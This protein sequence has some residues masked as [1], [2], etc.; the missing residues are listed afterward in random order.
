MSRNYI[1]PRA[2]DAG[3]HPEANEAIFDAAKRGWVKNI[4]FMAPG[5]TFDRA[6]AMSREIHGCDFG[7]HVSL[8]SEWLHQRFGPLRAREGAHVGADGHCVRT[9][10]IIFERGVVLDVLIDE[11]RAQHE[12]AV[13][14]G[15]R[16]SYLDEH[17][18]CS[19]LHEPGRPE[20]RLRDF[21]M[22]FCAEKGLVWYADRHQGSV[23]RE[24]FA[25]EI[26]L[27]AFLAGRAGGLLYL[28]HPVFNR[29]SVAADALACVE[30]DQ[31]GLEAAK[32]QVDYE[33]L[34]NPRWAEII[35]DCGFEILRYSEAPAVGGGGGR[36]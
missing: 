17:M 32:R 2:D 31:P 34:A 22:E 4:G 18:G 29:G 26:A 9:P 36:P 20:R 11:V 3:S 23:P 27:R 24:A 25:G 21:L 7:L 14:A 1:L 16:L 6:V 5:A 28:T 35:R 33:T 19:W 15:L 30:G 8:T 12:R 13:R 10:Q